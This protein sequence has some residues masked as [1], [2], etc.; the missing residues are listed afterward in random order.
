MDEHEE[1]SSLPIHQQLFLI[2]RS[3]NLEVLEYNEHDLLLEGDFRIHIENQ[4]LYKL[5]E[6]GKIIGPFDDPIEMMYFISQSSQQ[7]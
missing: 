4:S 2:C 1:L 7:I 5:I 3:F 6:K